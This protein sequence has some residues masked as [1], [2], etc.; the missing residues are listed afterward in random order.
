MRARFLSNIPNE[1]DRVQD[2]VERMLKL[3]ELETRESRASLLLPAGGRG[4]KAS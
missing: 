4:A 1:A 2:R 3:S